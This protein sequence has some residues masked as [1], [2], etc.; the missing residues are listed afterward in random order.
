M[1]NILFIVLFF[2]VTFLISACENKKNGELSP[3]L[4]NNSNSIDGQS[5]N[6]N[7]PIIEFAV[8]EHDFGKIIDGAKVSYTFKFKNIGGTDLIINQVKTS[9]GCTASKY[10]TEPVPPGGEGK[11]QLTF[12]GS[13]RRGFNNK[14][15]TVVANTQP[16]THMLKITAMVVGPDEL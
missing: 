14:V 12:D 7:P 4:I 5:N 16:N 15:A 10:T 1:K 11:V 6:Q 8:A 13:N 9:C 3:D 2:G